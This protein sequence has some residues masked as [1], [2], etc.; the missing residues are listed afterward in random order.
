MDENRAMEFTGRVLADTAAAATTV[1]AALGDRTG[2]FKDLAEHGPATSGELAVDPLGLLR[3]SRDA[4]RPGGRYLC[5]EINCSDR[6]TANVG[7]TATLLYAFSG[8]RRAE[9]DNPFNSLYELA[10]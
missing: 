6:A 10:R 9:M 8:V 3:S 4:L 2:L 1:L 7:P 5:L